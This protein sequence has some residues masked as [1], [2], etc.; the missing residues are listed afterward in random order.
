MRPPGGTLAPDE[1]LIATGNIHSWPFLSFCM[2]LIKIVAYCCFIVLIYHLITVFKFVE[3]PDTNEKQVGKKSRVKF[4]VMSLKV[5]EDV[6][7]VPELVS[8]K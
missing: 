7:Y 1:S 5:K 6:D 8:A 4:K 2:M 3:P